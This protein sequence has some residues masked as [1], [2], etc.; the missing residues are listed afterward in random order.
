MVSSPFNTDASQ[1][2]LDHIRRRRLRYRRNSGRI[3]AEIKRKP[4]SRPNP[5]IGMP[6]N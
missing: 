3:P 5:L 4:Y 1:S 6:Q 2:G